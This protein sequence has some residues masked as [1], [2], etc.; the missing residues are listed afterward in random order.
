MAASEASGENA[1]VGVFTYLDDT[2][3]AVERLKVGQ[4][5]FKAYSPTY[6][7]ELVEVIDD[8]RSPAAAISLMGALTGITGGFTLAVL[9]NLDYPIRVSAKDFVAPP[10]FVPVGYECTIL[11]CAI[12][13]LKA[14][15]WFCG[16]PNILRKVGYKPE[17]SNDKF[18]LVV[19]CG[20][21]QTG[22]V[23]DILRQSGADDV[24]TEQGL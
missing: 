16:L 12:F 7:P 3:K 6:V 11:F 9:C 4:Y 17:F 24:S 15:L 20:G 1:V 5:K 18:G 21:S 10:A 8:K 2:I 19:R 14:L 13:S 22:D 23:S